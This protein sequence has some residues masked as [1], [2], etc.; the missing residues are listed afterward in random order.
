MSTLNLEISE[1]EYVIKL[2]RG[3]YSLSTIQRLIKRIQNDY[4]APFFKEEVSYKD[5]RS[6]INDYF[7]EP[8]D[9]L[10]DK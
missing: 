6:H 9:H 1:K 10:S 5:V 3:T 2:D 7:N 4:N 8:Y